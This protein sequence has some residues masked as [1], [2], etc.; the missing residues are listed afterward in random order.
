[1]LGRSIFAII[2]I[3]CAYHQI[4]ML[5]GIRS[6]GFVAGALFVDRLFSAPINK[7]K[8]RHDEMPMEHTRARIPHHDSDLLS[9]VR[10]VAVYRAL[11]ARGFALLER[12]SVK[13]NLGVVQK[14]CAI[15]AKPILALVIIGAI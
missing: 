14:F 2:P 3:P 13:T 15:G 7:V 11:G 4:G 9:P 5:F 8:Q 10:L 1:M 12:A 6:L